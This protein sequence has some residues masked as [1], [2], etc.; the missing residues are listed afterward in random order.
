MDDVESS[1]SEIESE[2]YILTY[3][4]QPTKSNEDLLLWIKKLK[5][6]TTE[7]EAIGI[8]RYMLN[9]ISKNLRNG[10]VFRNVNK[11]LNVLYQLHPTIFTIQIKK[12]FVKWYL[13]THTGRRY[14]TTLDIF[15]LVTFSE[16][17]DLLY[18]ICEQT[19]NFYSDCSYYTI[20]HIKT[21]C[22]KFQE[23][24]TDIIK[25]VYLKSYY[26]SIY[27]KHI[28]SEEEIK[29]VLDKT[30]DYY[31]IYGGG[32][33]N[34]RKETK[35]ISAALSSEDTLYYKMLKMYVK[36]RK[37]DKETVRQLK[38]NLFSTSELSMM[39]LYDK[40]T[41]YDIKDECI[42]YNE[43]YNKYSKN[44]TKVELI[45]STDLEIQYKEYYAKLYAED[46][47][48]IVPLEYIDDEEFYKLALKHNYRV[49][50]KMPM[51]FV[52][53]DLC[54][55]LVKDI[56]ESFTRIPKKFVNEKLAI[57]AVKNSIQ[58][59]EHVHNSIMLS[60]TFLITVFSEPKTFRDFY[61]LKDFKLGKF[62]YVN[63]YISTKLNVE[64][65]CIESIKTNNRKVA[66]LPENL[67]TPEFYM[68][69]IKNGCNIFPHILPNKLTIEHYK[70][71]YLTDENMLYDMPY[72]IVKVLG[73]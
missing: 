5:K 50:N 59:L 24:P 60:P 16:F 3:Y 13:K 44:P 20:P 72:S 19:E 18:E 28:L 41:L 2:E 63:Y 6:P 46:E 64:E 71:G 68:T 30:S 65:I 26:Y 22:K 54:Y 15:N 23:D 73:K 57:I 32:R 17:T 7:E 45:E 1:Y 37:R 10:I 25:N 66:D 35:V 43:F 36:I 14:K 40:D 49:L 58:N 31:F 27:S 55:T 47:M 9:Y 48:Y 33:R 8:L 67:Q 53:Q 62:T 11:L 4:E 69:L 38:Q 52:T 21:A 42:S 56:P 39:L 34:S 61:N 12:N 70:Q 29:H 51:K